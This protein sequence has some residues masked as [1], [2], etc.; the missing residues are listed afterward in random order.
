MPVIE[1][2]EEIGATVEADVRGR[3]ALGPDAKETLFLVH[4]NSVGQYLLTPVVTIPKH[5][6]WLWNNPA[7]LADV[8]QGLSEA[9]AGLGKVVDFSQFA[10]IEIED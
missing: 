4:R 8:R 7:A 3:I 9:K 2:F 1:E 6:A 5:E 10:D